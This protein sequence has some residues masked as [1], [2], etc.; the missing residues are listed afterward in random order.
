MLPRSAVSW[1]ASRA[2]LDVFL[3]EEQR[4]GRRT[5]RGAGV[6]EALERRVH[7]GGGGG[8]GSGGGSGGGGTSR[9][10]HRLECRRWKRELGG[11][12]AEA[13]RACEGEARL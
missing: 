1:L 3:R 6:V 11:V 9:R 12:A 5:R 4:G 2:M 7:G 10:R 8:G 13:R